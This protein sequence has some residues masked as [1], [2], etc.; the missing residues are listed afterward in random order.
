M[1]VLFQGISATPIVETS[2]MGWEMRDSGIGSL[3]QSICRAAERSSEGIEL[4]QSCR[5]DLSR[6]ARPVKLLNEVVVDDSQI[7]VGCVL[8]LLR[9]L[10]AQWCFPKPSGS[11]GGDSH[12][13]PPL[14]AI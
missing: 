8:L 10:A 13:E 14:Y 6:E 2:D 11:T 5:V 7:Q 4:K 12:L 1:C 3:A 9:Q